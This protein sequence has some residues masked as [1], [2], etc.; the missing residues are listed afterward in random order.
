[1]PFKDLY[2]GVIASASVPTAF[3]PTELNGMKLVDGMTA[4]NTHV[5]VAIDRCL[6]KVDD[7]S[8]ITIDVLK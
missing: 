7:Y 5:Q 6:E 1:M 8:K 3:P 4:Y 2:K